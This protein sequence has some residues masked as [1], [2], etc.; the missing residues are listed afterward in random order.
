MS[1]GTLRARPRWLALAALAG[2]ASGD[3][4]GEAT[5]AAPGIDA[6]PDA[7]A[8]AAADAAPPPPSPCTPADWQLDPI[9]AWTES[10]VIGPVYP[11]LRLAADGAIDVA[12]VTSPTAG[13]RRRVAHRAPAGGWSIEELPGTTDPT[14]AETV[15]ADGVQLLCSTEPAASGRRLICVERTAGGA[16]QDRTLDE[17][18]GAGVTLAAT[19]DGTVELVYADV[20][21][22]SLARRSPTGAWTVAPLGIDRVAAIAV[23]GGGC[24]HAVGEAA[25]PATALQ[26]AVRCGGGTWT[27]EVAVPTPTAPSL[28]RRA[29]AIDAAGVVHVVYVD[30]VAGPDHRLFHARR[31]TDGAWDVVRV[32]GELTPYQGSPSVAVGPDGVAHAIFLGATP[33]ETSW[34]FRHVRLDDPA[35]APEPFGPAVPHNGSTDLVIDATG[36]LH[37][38]LDHGA[39]RL[40][41]ARACPG[42]TPPAPR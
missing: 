37:A 26:H 4:L 2:C 19:I 23:D 1:Q 6:A 10:M 29:L 40:D 21:G 17:R 31:G 42:A 41:H 35:A 9:D 38:V 14:V 27:T 34:R 20:D 13:Y 32:P 22:T 39:K 15:T 7:A 33:G 24:V 28:S 16:W 12:Y 18:T 3:A 11:S 25:P 8:D 36:A 5:D 30:W